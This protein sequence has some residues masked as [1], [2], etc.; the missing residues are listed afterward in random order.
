MW[1]RVTENGLE[2]NRKMWRSPMELYHRKKFS[3][4]IVQGNCGSG[5]LWRRALF[6]FRRR[7]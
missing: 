4:K 5:W 3:A 1:L 2:G 6:G 7:L